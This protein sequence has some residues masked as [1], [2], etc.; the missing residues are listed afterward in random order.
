MPDEIAHQ[1]IAVLNLEDLSDLNIQTGSAASVRGGRLGRTIIRTSPEASRGSIYLDATTR[2]NCSCRV[3]DSIEITPLEQPRSLKTVLLAPVGEEMDDDLEDFVGRNLYGRILG[4][5]DHITFPSPGGGILELQIEK[6]RPFGARIHGG[7]VDA[8]TEVRIAQRPARKPLLET[9]DV[10]FA[11]IGGMDSIIEK[12]QEVAVVPLLH[13]E[14]FIRGGKP[15]IRGILLHGE[16]GTGKSLLARAL[17]RETR[18]TFHSVSAHEVLGGVGG[19]PGEA[20][21]QLFIQAKND[22]PAV[23]FIDE[24]DVIAPDRHMSSECARK[25]VAQLLVLM[26]GMNDRGQVVVIGATNRLEA[27]DP[28]VIRSGRFERVIECE[29]PDRDGRLEI[30]EVHTRAM[31]LSEDVDI[32][33]LADLTVG[34]VGADI[35]HMCREGVYRAANRAFGFDRLLDMQELEASEMEITSHDMSDAFDLVRPSIKRKM[36]REVEKTSFESIIGQEEAKNALTEKML[37]PLEFPEL[38]EAAELKIGSG[39]LLHGPPGTGKT[40]LA[41]ACASI[42]G[43]QFLSVKGPELLSMWQ[44]ESER[45]A[46]NL[47]DKARKMSP[48][49]LFFDE[50]DSLGVDRG[51]IGAGFS[52]LSSIVNQILTEMD[53]IDSRDGILT[54]AATNRKDLIDPAFL[55]EGRLGTHVEVSLPTKEQY[56]EIMG[57]HLGGV[58]RSEEIDIGE[59]CSTLPLGLS[60]ADISGI[61]VRVRERAVKRHIQENPEGGVDG[62]QIEESDVR[63]AISAETPESQIAAW[64]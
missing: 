51:K 56:P 18:A 62:F 24:I 19:T 25:L 38:H 23:V 1:G 50:F 37:R 34:F 41:R 58:K 32:E 48:C 27:L 54:I 22:E 10:S 12:I 30:L 15:P 49:I 28:A 61:A 36:E 55:R 11:D 46:R 2:L 8:E 44:G 14:I 47:F 26:D 42:A 29:V 60:G 20:L 59:M 6:L 53:G 9:G 4:K 3:G 40:Q 17:A 43:A 39:I 64:A 21:H 16:P 45:A 52:G 31:P 5:G 57:V 13:P 7:V 63:L 35:D 33:E